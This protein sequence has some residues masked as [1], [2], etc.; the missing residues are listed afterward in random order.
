[1]AKI[2]GEEWQLKAP[3]VSYLIVPL[4]F[5]LQAHASAVKCTLRMLTPS[6][7]WLDMAVTRSLSNVFASTCQYE[8]LKYA[9]RLLISHT[10][11]I[12]S[13]A[14]PLEDPFVLRAN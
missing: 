6:G 11:F 1:M 7:G 8:A 5:S 4:G 10:E 14:A 2:R 3:L 12:L 9:A 13:P